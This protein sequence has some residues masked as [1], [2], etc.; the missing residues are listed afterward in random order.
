MIAHTN[1]KLCVR[2]VVTRKIGFY[3]KAG[4]SPRHYGYL[5][6]HCMKERASPWRHS[7]YENRKASN[8]RYGKLGE[9]MDR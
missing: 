8:K 2:V 7:H 3:E 9:S 5:R 1:K 4:K 6:F